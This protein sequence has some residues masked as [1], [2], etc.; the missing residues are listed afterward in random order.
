MSLHPGLH[1]NIMIGMIKRIKNIMKRTS[2]IWLFDGLVLFCLFFTVRVMML[3]STIERRLSVRK[4]FFQKSQQP[5]ELATSN[6]FRLPSNR[7][8]QRNVYGGRTGKTV[9]YERF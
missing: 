5:A 3:S 6:L 8:L 9:E 2:P 1:W 7:C 4:K